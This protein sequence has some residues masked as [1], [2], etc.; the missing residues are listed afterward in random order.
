MDNKYQKYSGAGNKFI[1]FNNLD[2]NI[3]NHSE[4]VLSLFKDGNNAEID[5]VIFVQKSIPGDFWMNYYN[6]DG[7]GNSLCGNG[8]R[9]TVQYIRDNGFTEK[10]DLLIESV[11]NLY[12]CIVLDENLISV[13]FPPPNIIRADLRLKVNFSGWGEDLK[14]SY[15]DVGSPHIVI[16]IDRL[17]KQELNTLEEVNVEEW[18]REIRLHKD[19]LPEGANVNFVQLLDSVNSEIALRTYERGVERETLACGTGALSSGLISFIIKDIKPPIK[20]L[21]RSGEFL[22]VN[23]KTDG[24]ELTDLTLTGKAL[25][26]E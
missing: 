1:I 17:Q 26:Y 20:I 10:N 13:A 12:R 11:G 15:V 5:G 23:F 22:T 25:R 6:K 7:T 16:F 21:T 19:L 8:L 3:I 2:D 9:C 4:T 18:G 14:C 24:N